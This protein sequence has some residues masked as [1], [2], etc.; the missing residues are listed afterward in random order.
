VLI[1]YGYL[2]RIKHVRWPKRITTCSAGGMGKCGRPEVKWEK[3][4]ER[5]IWQGNLTCDDA[6]NRR[7]W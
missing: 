2:V 7:L 5:E 4:V 3:G 1:L 6:V